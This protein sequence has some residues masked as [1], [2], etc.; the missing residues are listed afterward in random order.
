MPRLKHSLP[1]WF[2]ER[3]RDRERKKKKK[4]KK[5]SWC[6]NP[7]LL[8][9]ASTP[10]LGSYSSRNFGFLGLLLFAD[11]SGMPLYWIVCTCYSFC[12][13]CPVHTPFY[14]W[15]L[16]LPSYLEQDAPPPF[17]YFLSSF[18]PLFFLQSTDHWHYLT[19]LQSTDHYLTFYII[20]LLYCWLSISFHQHISLWRWRVLSLFPDA[21]PELEQCV[22]LRRHWHV[23]CE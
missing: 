9:C 23:A 10:L 4:K 16:S 18:P 13:E 8:P 12:L 11:I 17:K 7:W 22:P 15:G 21:S 3:E 2:W 5:E 20:F 14:L 19:F 1:F 6:N